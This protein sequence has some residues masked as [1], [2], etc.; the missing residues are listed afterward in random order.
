[1]SG[2]SAMLP[3]GSDVSREGAPR[4]ALVADWADSKQGRCAPLRGLRRS[5]SAI[6]GSD[7]G[8]DVIPAK[9]EGSRLE[10]LPHR[11]HQVLG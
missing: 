7:F 5:H 6:E 2:R 10:T 3:C 8:R 9:D 1:M 4:R 11:C